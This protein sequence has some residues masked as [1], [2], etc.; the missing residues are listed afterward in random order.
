MSVLSLSDLSVSRGRREVVRKVSFNAEAGEFIGLLGPN[1][2]GKTSLFRAVLGLL[3]HRGQSSLSSMAARDRAL[4]AAWAPQAREIAWPIAVETLV[5]LG[6]LPHLAA[7]AHPSVRDHEAVA[8]ALARMELEALAK[9][10]ATGLSGGEQARAL[11]A[12]VL[13][14]DTPLIL[15]DEPIAGLDPAHQISTMVAF[16][17][18]AAEGRTLIVS[19]HDL[20]LAARYCTRMIVLSDGEL[21]ADG[22]PDQVLTSD[23]LARVFGIRAYVAETEH[24]LVVQPEAVLSPVERP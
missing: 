4:H 13:A 18:L 8:D 14:Q 1:G 9:R 2:A 24:G 19:L 16:R 7:G 12:R 15:A 22:T 6:R 21:A 3:P 23:I 20:G 5:M 11:L 17:D 10:P